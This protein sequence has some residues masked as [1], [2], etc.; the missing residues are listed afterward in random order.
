LSRCL[1][2]QAGA[3]FSRIK[4]ALKSV[5]LVNPVKKQVDLLSR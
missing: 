2:P 5:N 3:L 4:T 1:P